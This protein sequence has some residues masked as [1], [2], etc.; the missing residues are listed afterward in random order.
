MPHE[1]ISTPHRFL[2]TAGHAP[3]SP[4]YF[5]RGDI[6][7]QPTTWSALADQVRRAARGL[8]ALGVAPGDRVSILAYNRPEWVILD[9]AAMMV[10]AV[11]IGIYFTAAPNE[12]AFI[13]K[14]SA[15]VLLAAENPAQYAKLA[16]RRNEF[17]LVRRVIMMDGPAM[18]SWQITWQDFLTICGADLDDEVAARMD[19]IAPQNPGTLLYTSGTTGTPKAVELSHAALCSCVEVINQT[20]PQGPRDRVICYLPL[21][22]IAEKMLSVHAYA[23]FGTKLYFARSVQEL[24]QHLTEVRPTIFFGVPRVWEKLVSVLRQKLEAATG[25]KAK[26]AAWAQDIGRA[27]AKIERDGKRPT[28]IL[29]IQKRIAEKLVH[30]KIKAAI[31]LD[32][33]RVLFSG[34]APIAPE[35]LE[36]LAGLDVIVYE[37]YG[38]SETCGPTTTNLPGAN[39][40]GSVGRAVPGTELRIAPDGEVLV[41][42]AKLL[43]G[44][45]GRPDATAEILIDG[46]L[47][48]GDLGRLDADGYLYITGRKKDLIITAGGKNISPAAIEA[49]LEAIPIIEHAVIYGDRKP[50][51]AALITLNPDHLAD[52]ARA[53][54]LEPE[55][56]ALHEL[57]RAEVQ[58]GIDAVNAEQS[59]VAAIR[60]FAILPGRFTVETGELTP[61]LKTKRAVI[62]ERHKPVLEA[63]YEK[64]TAGG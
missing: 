29:D 50:F 55:N 6:A 20:M 24:S 19:A 40:L 49:A 39:R 31:G 53:N 61:T 25:P 30:S 63:M 14:D 45:A 32:A 35:V 33:A 51:C 1:F 5:T 9:L 2:N 48:S 27:C 58:R 8:I 13:L 52:L 34:A 64:E 56:A 54:G 17:P 23:A 46:W 26:I 44:Y 10:G 42:D 38:Q 59:R 28:A 47:Y 21:A 22:H 43:T 41:R 36:F 16:G 62:V 4:A 57:V 37:L 3:G 12:A 7:W 60:K 18:D 15:S 11:P